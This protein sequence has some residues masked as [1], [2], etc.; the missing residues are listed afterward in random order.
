MPPG[1]SLDDTPNTPQQDSQDVEPG[2]PK[3]EQK[4]NAG[5]NKGSVISTLSVSCNLH[6]FAFQTSFRSSSSAL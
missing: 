3:I 2:S 6:E 1:K 5:K 4:A